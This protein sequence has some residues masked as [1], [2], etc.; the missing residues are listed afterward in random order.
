MIHSLR[1]RL[2]VAFTLVIVIAVGTVF[3]F[4]NQ[5]TQGEFRQFSERS[6]HMRF[7]RVGFELSRYYHTQGSWEGIQSYV[8]Q[9]GNLYGKRIILT[10]L[11]GMVLA[12]S[13][14]DLLGE[15]YHADT[16]GMPLSTPRGGG[17]P[18]RLYIS[19]ETSVEL[20]S[21]QGLSRAISYFLLWGGLL[22][23]AIALLITFF[24]SRRI[25]APIKSITLASKRLGQRDFSQ[26]VQIK[27]KGEIGEL[28]NTFNSMTTDLEQAEELQRNMVADIAHEL[29]TPLSNIKGYLEAFR[30]GVIKADTGTIQ[31]LDEEATLLLRLVDD[32]QELS[33]AEAGELKLNRQAENIIRLIQQT[34]SAKRH[35]AAAKGVLVSTDLP[36][37]LPMGNI[38][39]HRINQ[40][41]LNLLDNAIAH[42]AKDGTIIVTAK[43]EGNWIEVAVTDT[44]KGIPPEDLPNVF[45][46]FYRVDKSRT[47][48]TG[49]SSLGLTI[50]K[51]LVE[52]HGGKI[53]VQSELGKGSCF[54]FT[55]HVSE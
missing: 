1:F 38:D 39:A 9:W 32:L 51:R 40:V 55:V 25:S 4:V 13:E 36:D 29:R 35:Q 54:S 7:T 53:K 24:L 20:P 11:G 12:D 50:T 14:G 46:R 16:P 37:N 22:A 21:T 42:T 49:G 5:M 8:E 43:Q 3:F 18:G 2:L 41:L 31:S 30:D 45:E 26:R 19:P 6:E 17:I 34:V 27:E 44:G 10:D 52:A 28:A 33:L 48:A 23:I 15:Q 47:R